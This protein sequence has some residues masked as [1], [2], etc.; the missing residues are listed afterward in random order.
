MGTYTPSSR[1]I[2]RKLDQHLRLEFWNR[3]IVDEALQ[4]FTIQTRHN[5]LR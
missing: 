1:P 2:L 4:N 5:I 3:E